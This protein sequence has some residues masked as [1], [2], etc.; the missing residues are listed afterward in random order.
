M[1]RTWAE[2]LNPTY[3]K[4]QSPIQGKML[5]AAVMAD[6]H[7]LPGDEDDLK[8]LDGEFFIQILNKRIEVYKLPI[9][10]TPAAKLAVMSLVDRAGSVVALLIDCLNAYEGKAVTAGMLTDLYSEGFYDEDTLMRY[11]DGYLK[12]RKVKWSEIY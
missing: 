12:T 1:N 2:G 6:G 10:F 3:Q 5:L 9:S 7:P 4:L 11:V 8:S